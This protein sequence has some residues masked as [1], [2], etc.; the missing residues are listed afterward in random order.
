MGFVTI[1]E[2]EDGGCRAFRLT[3]ALVEKARDAF[4]AA[5][6]Q[7]GFADEGRDRDDPDVACRPNGFR[8][9]D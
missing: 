5:G 2:L 6:A 1:A 4:L 9:Q 8:R 3:D 7:D